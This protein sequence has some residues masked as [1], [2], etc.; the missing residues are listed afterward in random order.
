MAGTV[1]LLL[2]VIWAVKWYRDGGLGLLWGSIVGEY[3]VK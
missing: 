3:R 2:V 1:A